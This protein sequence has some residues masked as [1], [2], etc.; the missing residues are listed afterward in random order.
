MSLSS[1]DWKQYYDR[2]AE[3][4]SNFKD[5]DGLFKKVIDKY[6]NKMSGKKFTI[7]DVL[8]EY[9]KRKG[10]KVSDVDEDVEFIVDFIVEE[11]EVNNYRV[12]LFY[13]EN[14]IIMI[15]YGKKTTE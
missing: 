4:I 15:S 10:V 14:P 9:A 13:S 3:R 8:F 2:W 6:G 7:F 5:V 11:Y 12:A 1:E